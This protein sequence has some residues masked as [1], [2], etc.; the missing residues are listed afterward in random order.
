MG[1]PPLRRE[2]Q[3]NIMMMVSADV[4][5]RKERKKKKI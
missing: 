5:R 2:T 4:K 1:H 3:P